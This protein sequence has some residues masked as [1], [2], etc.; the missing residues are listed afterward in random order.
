ML[1]A[2]SD[3]LCVPVLQLV[4]RLLQ[5]DPDVMRVEI[6]RIYSQHSAVLHDVALQILVCGRTL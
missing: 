6:V 1:A 3:H 4:S 5:D 2:C